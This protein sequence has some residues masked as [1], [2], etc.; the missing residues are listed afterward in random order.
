MFESSD[1]YTLLLPEQNQLSLP[2][3]IHSEETKVIFKRLA[4]PVYLSQFALKHTPR[5]QSFLAAT[6]IA[7]VQQPHQPG[8]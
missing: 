7:K 5:K 1:V 4:I 8:T 2:D 3:R 6:N